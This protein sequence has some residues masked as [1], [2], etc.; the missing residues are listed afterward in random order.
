MLEIP[1]K[2]QEEY[3]K[4]K[5]EHKHESL[6][7][8]YSIP[9]LNFIEDYMQ[10]ISKVWYK[11]YN[12]NELNIQGKAGAIFKGFFYSEDPVRSCINHRKTNYYMKIEVDSIENVY[13][14]TDTEREFGAVLGKQFKKFRDYLSADLSFIKFI[15]SRGSKS[16]TW[17]EDRTYIGINKLFEDEDLRELLPEEIY[18][19]FTQ[20]QSI[21]DVMP[22]PEELILQ[23]RFALEKKQESEKLD[24]GYTQLVDMCKDPLIVKMY[25]NC[26]IQSIINRLKPYR[27]HYYSN[28]SIRYMLIELGNIH[29][30]RFILN[31]LDMYI[32]I[33]DVLKNKGYDFDAVY[34]YGSYDV[35]WTE[36]QNGKRLAT[37]SER[38]SLPPNVSRERKYYKDSP[39]YEAQLKVLEW[40]YN[41]NKKAYKE[42]MNI[43]R[44]TIPK[45][46]IS[47]VT[48]LIVGTAKKVKEALK[49]LSAD[50]F[51]NDIDNIKEWYLAQPRCLDTAPDEIKS[52]T[53]KELVRWANSIVPKTRRQM[54]AADIAKKVTK[55][56][57]FVE[58]ITDKQLWIMQ[59]AY[60]ED[61][62]IQ[63]N[64]TA[65]P[66][67]MNYI[68][69]AKEVVAHKETILKY[70]DKYNFHIKVATT[71]AAEEKVSEK[72]GH[73]IHEV[74][75]ALRTK[76]LK[77]SDTVTS[78]QDAYIGI[79]SEIKGKDEAFATD[80]VFD[81]LQG[82]YTGE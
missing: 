63:T 72:Q 69:E 55:G 44:Y 29:N 16:I 25:K 17:Y 32:H 67:L 20:W 27:K 34:K 77:N 59:A 60:R 53:R 2:V 13:G 66:E 48:K 41:G 61:K 30:C 71:V 28:L 19:L 46:D 52:L 23:Y 49:L 43:K 31:M 39:V 36:A 35:Y 80:D 62:N 74:Y 18:G 70:T 79:E 3:H 64:V 57:M 45:D 75:T 42:F 38:D 47:V 6:L 5:A 65:S 68:L 54:I 37:L 14:S 11:R 40:M 51:L 73:Y 4:Y 15:K 24:M 33:W 81:M 82:I 10:I 7:S 9:E 1:I 56:S 22:L 8:G 76:L 26:D 78:E 50:E 21:R 58:E 12:N